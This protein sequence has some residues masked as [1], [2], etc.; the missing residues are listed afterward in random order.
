M[1]SPFPDGYGASSHRLQLPFRVSPIHTRETRRR[2]VTA[3]THKSHTFRGFS[4]TA[5]SQPKGA[6]YLRQHP[7][8]PVTLRPQGFSPSRRFAPLMTCQAYFILVPL[9]GFTLRGFS[10]SYGAVDPFESRGL[11]GVR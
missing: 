6:T 8:L 11:H 2:N 9:M 7:T 4:P 3:T 5:S 1:P 10:P